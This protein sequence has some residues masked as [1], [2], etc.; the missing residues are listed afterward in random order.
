MPPTTGFICQRDPH[1]APAIAPGAG[2]IKGGTAYPEESSYPS[3]NQAWIARTFR[4]SSAQPAVS[5]A[6][7]RLG[8]WLP[9]TAAQNHLRS[10][11][12]S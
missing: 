5:A 7:A 11:R 3:V 6:P 4:P 2:S 9:A 10:S 8:P 12:P 1:D